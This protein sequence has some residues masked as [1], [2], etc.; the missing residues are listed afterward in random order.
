M[1]KEKAIKSSKREYLSAVQTVPPYQL[2]QLKLKYMTDFK[3]NS[4]RLRYYLMAD[5]K[6]CALLGIDTEKSTTQGN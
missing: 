5:Q 4:I 1:T 2:N 6:Y 3:T